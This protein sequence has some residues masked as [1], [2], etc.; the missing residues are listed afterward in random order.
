MNFFDGY[1]LGR[2]LGGRIGKYRCLR[3][4]HIARL[5]RG[6]FLI[7]SILGLIPILLNPLQSVEVAIDSFHFGLIIRSYAY[8]ASPTTFF[9]RAGGL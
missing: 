3:V 4:G 5:P 1:P 7:A 9:Q 2:K 8:F 6:A